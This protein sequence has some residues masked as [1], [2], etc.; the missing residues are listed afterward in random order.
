MDIDTYQKIANNTHKVTDDGVVSRTTRNAEKIADVLLR[1]IH[2]GE[3]AD[4]LKRELFY[5]E[6]EGEFCEKA[7][8]PTLMLHALLGILSEMPE[9]AILEDGVISLQP[10]VVKEE[11]GDLL[12]YLMLLFKSAELDASGVISAN[13]E[14]LKAR[15]DGVFSAEK[16]LNRDLDKEQEIFNA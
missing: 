6:D 11:G 12:W 4:N 16:A 3:Q 14:K 15:Y 5:K 7:D 10:K 9:L 13:V 8:N 2:L 1:A